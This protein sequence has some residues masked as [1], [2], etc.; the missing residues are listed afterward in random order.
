[1]YITDFLW[2]MLVSPLTA[3]LPWTMLF[4][5]LQM[6]LEAILTTLLSLQ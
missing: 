5:D 1:M 6:F 4:P 2:V 3:F